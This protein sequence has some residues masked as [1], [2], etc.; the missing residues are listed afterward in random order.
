MKTLVITFEDTTKVNRRL[1]ENL[2]G[3][4]FENEQQ[5]IE[6][7]NDKFGVGN[8]GIVDMNVFQRELN[9]SDDDYRSSFLDGWVSFVTIREEGKQYVKVDEEAKTIDVNGNVLSFEEVSLAY[10]NFTETV[11]QRIERDSTGSA[12][13]DVILTQSF[14]RKFTVKA[15]NAEDA[16][17]YVDGCLALFTDADYVGESSVAEVCAD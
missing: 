11:N 5:L 17:D 4:V 12:E 1:A 2:T 10:S 3:Q 6:M 16:I 14:S 9:D 13:F 15:N 8:F 7:L